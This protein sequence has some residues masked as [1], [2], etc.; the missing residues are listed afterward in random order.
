[1][2]IFFFST[3]QSKKGKQQWQAKNYQL[4][5]EPESLSETI[6]WQEDNL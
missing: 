4:L 5:S 2:K 3:T 6:F 1:V